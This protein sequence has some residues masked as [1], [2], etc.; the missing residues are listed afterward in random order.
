MIFRLFSATSSHC[1][2]S[3]HTRNDCTYNLQ[4]DLGHSKPFL[5]SPQPHLLIPLQPHPLTAQPPHST[6]I[7]NDRCTTLSHLTRTVQPSPH[8][9][10]LEETVGGGTTVAAVVS[11]RNRDTLCA[12]C[13]HTRTTVECDC[14][15]A[16]VCVHVCVCMCVCACVCVC[17]CVCACVCVCTCVCACVCVCVPAQLYVH[18][19]EKMFP[20]CSQ[21]GNRERVSHKQ[22]EDE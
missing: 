20:H 19:K 13:T 2:P 3:P 18:R 7:F 17:T 10:L 1:H 8:T 21:Y 4:F 11:R 16:C 22:W 5:T 14:V 9:A 15:C 6:H 12:V